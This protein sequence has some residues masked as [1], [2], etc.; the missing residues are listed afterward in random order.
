[1][2]KKTVKRI[3]HALVIITLMAILGGCASSNNTS[4]KVVINNSIFET[5][6]DG[7]TFYKDYHDLTSAMNNIRN[8]V[9]YEQGKTSNIPDF[10]MKTSIELAQYDELAK[11]ENNVEKELEDMGEAATSVLVKSYWENCTFVYNAI[12]DGRITEGTKE[13]SSD[14]DEAIQHLVNDSNSMG[15]KFTTY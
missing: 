6:S 1:M 4:N 3:P 8:N 11:I 12:K 13:L 5:E 9:L 2:N 10:D 15:A 14:I 7:F